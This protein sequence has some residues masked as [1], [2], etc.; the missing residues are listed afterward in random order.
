MLFIL[1]TKQ[2][3]P[4]YC[5]YKEM[6]EHARSGKHPE[7]PSAVQDGLWEDKTTT[8]ANRNVV[9]LADTVTVPSFSSSP[10]SK[11][12]GLYFLTLHCICTSFSCCSLFHVRSSFVQP[13]FPSLKENNL[14]T[15]LRS[16]KQSL[17]PTKKSFSRKNHLSHSLFLLM[18]APFQFL[19]SCYQ[20]GKNPHNH[21]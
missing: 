8:I 9:P 5:E 16:L 1:S 4:D 6:Q 17:K 12:P 10:D 18:S 3:L 14:V 13:C 19:N 21:F 2:S 7:N 11:F 20:K 15:W